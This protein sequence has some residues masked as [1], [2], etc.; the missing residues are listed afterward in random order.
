MQKIKA[1][2]DKLI[3]SRQKKY[4]KDIIRIETTNVC[5]LK[6]KICPQSNGM[7]NVK[8][9]FMNPSLFKKIIDQITQYPLNKNSKLY[10][11]ICGEPLLHKNIIEFIR[12]SHDL[13]LKPI[14]TTNATKLT[15]SMACALIDNGL[16]KIEFSF[17]GIDPSI[18]ESVRTGSDYHLVNNNILNF[19]TINNERNKKVLTELVVVDLP[20]IQTKLK[21]DYCNQMKQHFNIINLSGYMDWVGKV[22][23]KKYQRT[24]YRGCSVIDTDLNVLWDGRV[25]PCCMDIYGELTIGDFN[26]M[27][28]EEII[29]LK[30]RQILKKRLINNDLNGLICKKCLVP[31]GGR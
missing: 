27:P 4:V 10:L 14:L 3:P 1:I 7:R 31:W 24:D 21:T 30:E 6:C 16:H 26:T 5:N 19:L 9:G 15:Q 11:H 17:E 23:V 28:Y 8:R 29:N 22:E 12:Y 13:G 2:I 18:Y 25:I 20:F